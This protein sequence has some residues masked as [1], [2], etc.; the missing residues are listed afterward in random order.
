M[1]RS[2]YLPILWLSLL[3]NETT[4]AQVTLPYY[5]GFDD[6]S[7]QAGWTEYKKASTEFSHWVIGGSSDPISPPKI[8]GHSYSPSTGITLTDNWFVSPSFAIPNGGQL[9]S[10]RY[11]FSGMSV[12]VAGDT[13]ALYLLRGSQDPDLATLKVL[14]IDFR[15]TDY[16][17]DYTW[18]I[19]TAIP[20]PG[21]AEPS[22]LALRYRNTDCSSKWLTCQLDNIA[23]S[24]SNIGIHEN[25]PA[26][27]AAVY[28]N[29]TTGNIAI[30]NGNE[31]HAVE[32]LNLFGEIVYSDLQLMLHPLSEADLS[33][34][35]KGIYVVRFY[36]A[37]T[38]HLQRMVIR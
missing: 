36:T 4:F 1:K 35:P 6:A 27:S 20:L 33:S 26:K 23:I 7:Q 24:A 19:K 14:L 12:P 21:S 13:V 15:N 11:Y 25:S 31:A 32:I 9:D 37:T 3:I 22:Y 10:I 5:T 28:P 8:V 30:D 38:S 17:N 29:P 16:V 34:L 18:R 2:F